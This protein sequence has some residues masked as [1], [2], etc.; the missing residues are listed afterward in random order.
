MVNICHI[1]ICNTYCAAEDV[2]LAPGETKLVHTG[3]KMAVP[4]GYE[5]QV[6]PRSG[7]SLK[8]PLRVANAPG[9]IDTGYRDEV[10]VIMQNTS[11]DYVLSE[12]GIIPLNNVPA[13]YYYTNEKNNGQGWYI[14]NKGD[15]IA[16]LVFA[17]IAHAELEIVDDV[18]LIG[19]NRGGGFGSTG[20][21]G[22]D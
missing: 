11:K 21:K 22:I 12:G 14:I 15:R 18:K 6:R 5:C 3:L 13:N 17:K 7:L 9:T 20:V 16:Q 8:T 1:M 2:V 4:E 10:C 19:D